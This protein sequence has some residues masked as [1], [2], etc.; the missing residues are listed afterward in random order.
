MM[1]QS[2]P[3]AVGDSITLK[4]TV[5]VSD[6]MAEK[7]ASF[8]IVDAIKESKSEIVLGEAVALVQRGKAA[9]RVKPS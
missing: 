7:G 3:L 6:R 8:S 5:T 2:K 9:R 4:Q 1:S